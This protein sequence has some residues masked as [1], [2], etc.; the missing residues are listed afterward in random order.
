MSSTG[1]VLLEM[2]DCTSNLQSPCSDPGYPY[3]RINGTED[4][5]DGVWLFSAGT[6]GGD[7]TDPTGVPA[8]EQTD[9]I[10]NAALDYNLFYM[11]DNT[12]EVLNFTSG[13]PEPTGAHVDTTVGEVTEGLLNISDFGLISE[14]DDD[15]G[16]FDAGR[17][18]SVQVTLVND[19][20]GNTMFIAPDGVVATGQLGPPGANNPSAAEDA[21]GGYE[22]FIFEDAELS[23]MT[24]RLRSLTNDI[25]ITIGDRQVNPHTSSGAD[26][27]LIAIDLDSL[28]GFDGTFISSITITDDNNVMTSSPCPIYGDTSM[29]I[30]AILSRRSVLQE[31]AS[32]GDFVWVDCNESGYYDGIQQNESGYPGVTVKLY[33]CNTTT[34]IATTTTN[35][36][37]YYNFTNLEL[38][39]YYL[40][41]VPPSGYMWTLQDQG[42][43]DAL[44]SDINASTD[45]TACFTLTSGQ[46][47]LTRD[48]GLWTGPCMPI[49]EMSTVV[50]FST[51]LLTLAGY[52]V[53]RSR[54]AGSGDRRRR[55]ESLNDQ[56]DIRR[57]E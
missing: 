50:L 7:C 3:P 14:G 39:S 32:V 24:I 26:D 48:A 44:D 42:Q 57:Q 46:I 2:S 19:S 35:Q 56:N 29:E 25:N 41:F 16:N 20:S 10:I 53:V 21:L 37:G 9:D 40:E 28:E 31:A 33:L 27:T 38:R 47:D 11:G 49:P 23:G 55:S 17:G 30:D 6:S 36:S 13:I 15:T 18:G 54:N 34:P 5:T 4:D 12:F 52:L 51:G 43:D 22:I 8:G 45:K 1:S